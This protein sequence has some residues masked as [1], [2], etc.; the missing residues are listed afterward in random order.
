MP[1]RGQIL[2]ASSTFVLAVALE[3]RLLE[4]LQVRGNWCGVSH[5]YDKAW[6]GGGWSSSKM[7]SKDRRRI[8]VLV[9]RAAYSQGSSSSRTVL[10]TST[11]L[12]NG[13]LIGFQ[14]APD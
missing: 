7:V 14:S 3:A 4:H 2:A 11:V 5:V 1:D 9:E 12:Y 13:I 8:D 10:I 6:K